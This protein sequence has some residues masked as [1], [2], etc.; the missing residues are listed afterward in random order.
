M[1]SYGISLACEKVLTAPPTTRYDTVVLT[2]PRVW[3]AAH[4]LRCACTVLRMPPPLAPMH[5]VGAV[6]DAVAF[7][8]TPVLKVI[9]KILEQLI[10]PIVSV[11]LSTG[12]ADGA[13]A[14]A[15]PVVS[16]VGG[17]VMAVL[18]P[19]LSAVSGIVESVTV[20]I[21]GAMPLPL[22]FPW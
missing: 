15:T 16:K 17:L 1:H 3:S 6:I 8:V 14:V 4:L 13:A 12:I 9:G 21:E 20:I 5:M 18:R 7:L 22:Y 2:D 10:L 11:L 19:P